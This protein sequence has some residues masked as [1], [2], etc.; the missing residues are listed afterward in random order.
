M[1]ESQGQVYKTKDAMKAIYLFL[2][3]IIMINCSKRA[4]EKTDPTTCVDPSDLEWL[5][6]KK[7]EYSSCT[8]L[9]GARQAIY[10]NQPV[11][12]IYLY[13]PL[14]NGFNTVYKI[15][16]SRWFISSESIY[17]DYTANL[18]EQRTIWTCSGDDQ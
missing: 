16:G 10:Q 12:E 14:C 15:D 8:C 5:A 2:L 13:D 18:K 3:A 11:I 17:T 9:V 4:N 6:A 7:R 1:R